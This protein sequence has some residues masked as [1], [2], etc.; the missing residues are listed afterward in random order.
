[1]PEDLYEML[2]VSKDASADDIKR[3]YRRKAREYHPDAGGDE[4][5]F[6]KVTHAHNVLSD[7]QTRARYDRF[8]DDGTPSTR[9][10]GDPF[11]FGA[12][13]FGGINDVIDAFFGSAFGG[14]T[15]SRQR[16]AG[17]D[18]LVVVDVTLDEVVTGVQRNVEVEAA[19]A[20]STCG[21]FGSADGAS[22]G[23]CQ[24]CG[25]AGQVQR[26]VRTAF[27]Q[28]ATASPCPSC[29]GS[30]RA[31]GEPCTGCSG[32]GRRSERRT[33]TIDIPAGVEHGDRLRLRG[34]GEAGRHGATAGD[35]YVEIHVA[36]HR[37]YERDGRDLFAEVVIPM[38]QAALGGKLT[39][40][41]IDGDDID[42]A[43]PA[44]SQSG[45]VLVVKK[46]GLPAKGGGRR[47]DLNLVVRVEVPTGLD[48]KQRELLRDLA[49][50]RGDHLES[51]GSG[52][53]ARLRDVMQR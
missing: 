23:R 11:G 19:A 22:L 21:G 28:M 1:M 48:D 30:G 20:C 26:V 7:P 9:G 40:P 14:Q 33:L 41:S 46:A 31:I 36:E 3:A 25:G 8:G 45:D 16:S 5:M 27:G 24:T 13:G 32:E 42:V 52:L 4:E 29:K 50:L 35:L 17:R 47:G 2:G 37:L 44:G 12:Q 43:V 15:S 34:S 18:V 51:S 6:K 38:T 39:I 53:F 49:N 10:A